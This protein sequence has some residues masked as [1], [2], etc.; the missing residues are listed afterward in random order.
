MKQAEEI[1]KDQ[2]ATAP[3]VG[4]LN[5]SFDM[6]GIKWVTGNKIL[7][8]AIQEESSTDLHFTT[9]SPNNLILL[10]EQYVFV[11]YAGDSKLVPIFTRR[12]K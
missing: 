10:G 7:H 5:N 11:G 4:E 8:I 12:K 1:F 6:F 9:I 3:L 2:L